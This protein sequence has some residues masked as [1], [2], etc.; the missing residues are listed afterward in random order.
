MSL[1]E[2]IL[3][4][5]ATEP[6]VPA[7]AARWSRLPLSPRVFTRLIA[8]EEC[9]SDLVLRLR[10]LGLPRD[11]PGELL[12]ELT[13]RSRA[14]TARMLVLRAQLDALIAAFGAAAVPVTLLKGAAF[15]KT[16]LRRHRS[17]SDIDLLV[18]RDD[19]DSAVRA[20]QGAGYHSTGSAKLANSQ[21]LP[22][23]VREDVPTVE[24]HT[25]A[26]YRV[27]GE[28]EACW[29]TE[30]IAPG[31]GVL[32]PTDWCWH[33]LAHEAVHR[34]TAGRARGA[35]DVAVLVDRYGGAIDWGRIAERAAAWPD[36]VESTVLS[37][38]R[39]GYAVPLAV[40]RRTR[41]SSACTARAREYAARVAA[42]DD[43]FVF[44]MLK[45]GGLTF[46]SPR[47]WVA[48]RR[49]AGV[50]ARG[51]VPAL[52]RDAARLARIMFGRQVM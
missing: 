29:E 46:G 11:A 34:E 35:L 26:L 32:S 37:V 45:I 36:S 52:A 39:L 50:S 20:L 41:L 47:T 21:H 15:I 48:Y 19:V 6:N 42:T 2:L 24:L 3:D 28:G 43:Q 13:A 44:A 17:C 4:T 9:A 8:V 5:F 51:V 49:A 14:E 40:S 25:R 38:R 22:P 27:L 7:L 1:R 33:A 12:S 30:E 23:F 10:E 16:G 18:A 31:L